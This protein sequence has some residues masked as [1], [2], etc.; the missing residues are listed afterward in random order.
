MSYLNKVYIIGR[1]VA[2]PEPGHTPSGTAATTFTIACT[3]QTK[4]ETF[5]SFIDIKAYG[6]AAE[7]VASYATKGREIL[8]EG[9]LVQNKWTAKDGTQ[10]SKIFVLCE[11]VQFLSPKQH[12]GEP[13]KGTQQP[14]HR[15]ESNKAGTYQGQGTNAPYGE[16][17]SPSEAEE[18]IPF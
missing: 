18:D 17:W 1:I 8:V 6:G 2:Q 4:E 16:S 3:R 5:T 7:I 13:Q 12:T 10:R 15:V 9:A 11:R 14:A